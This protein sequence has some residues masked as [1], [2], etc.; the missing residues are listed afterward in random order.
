[1]REEVERSKKSRGEGNRFGISLGKVN[2]GG[3]RMGKV[4]RFGISR[5]KKGGKVWEKFGKEEKV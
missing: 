1:M 2:L 4:E 5:R 3:V